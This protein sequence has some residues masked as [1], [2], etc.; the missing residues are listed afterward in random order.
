[1]VV[2]LMSLRRRCTILKTEREA[3]ESFVFPAIRFARHF[4]HCFIIS[5]SFLHIAPP[6][7]IPGVARAWQR[8]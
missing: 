7:P 5:S 3:L 4:H 6:Y 2:D 8:E 1:M